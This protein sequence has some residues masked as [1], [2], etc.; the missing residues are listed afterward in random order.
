MSAGAPAVKCDIQIPE[1]I[2]HEKKTRPSSPGRFQKTGSLSA[3]ETDEWVK[4]EYR[5]YFPSFYRDGLTEFIA[6]DKTSLQTHRNGLMSLQQFARHLNTRDDTAMTDVRC[7]V[8]RFDGT[9][10]TLRVCGSRRISAHVE[11]R[12][13]EARIP[14][15]ELRCCYCL[16]AGSGVVFTNGRLSQVPHPKNWPRLEFFSSNSWFFQPLVES[17]AN[18]LGFE[19]TASEL[20]RIV[21]T[22]SDAKSNP[23]MDVALIAAKNELAVT[24]RFVDTAKQ[25]A[26]EYERLLCAEWPE[27]HHLP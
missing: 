7:P 16:C 25:I 14:L 26:S 4:T 24:L 5:R 9:N 17:D 11:Y 13:G 23:A 6:I 15:D 10:G 22:A 8:L 21:H 20:E 19:R 3:A 27:M 2:L 12:P 18:V 1:M